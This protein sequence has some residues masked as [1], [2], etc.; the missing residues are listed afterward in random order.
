[1]VPGNHSQ[2]VSITQPDTMSEQVVVK[3]LLGDSAPAGPW[4]SAR[5]AV[6]RGRFDEV[7]RKLMPIASELDEAHLVDLALA[8]EGTG[9]NDEAL[10]L[11][12]A[13]AGRHGTD[14]KG[15]LAGRLKRAWLLEGRRDDAE[16]ALALY[17]EALEEATAADD[18][19]QAYYHA[20]NVAFLKLAYEGDRQSGVAL[21][22]VALEHCAAAP[23]THWRAATQAEANL[24]CGD[25]DEALARYSEAVSLNPDPR[26]F[27]S[28]WAQ[29]M[30][31][32]EK[33]GRTDLA[34][35]IYH[36]FRPSRP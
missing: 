28:I 29:A 9:R 22:E 35:R 33:L 34:E 10:E 1:M 11:L 2:I 21:A 4:N 20:I 8:L 16:S 36:L 14:A 32:A 18:H 24:H 15:V 30:H 19:E 6:E 23:V 5:V 12:R 17:T 31:L 7:I 27:E 25:D 26:D 3:G 13:E